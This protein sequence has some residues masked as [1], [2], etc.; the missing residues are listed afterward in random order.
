VYDSALSRKG[1]GTRE[2]DRYLP[3]APLPAFRVSISPYADMRAYTT[4][5]T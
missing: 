4:R 3:G 2:I 5:R 1:R